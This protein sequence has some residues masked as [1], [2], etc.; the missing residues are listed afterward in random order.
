[1]LI[2][3]GPLAPLLELLLAPPLLLLLLLPH[4]P[5]AKMLP[6][7]RHPVTALPRERMLLLCVDARFS[8]LGSA[9]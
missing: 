3:F 7:S 1:M 4:A 5:S 6:A 9:A 8:V 2:V